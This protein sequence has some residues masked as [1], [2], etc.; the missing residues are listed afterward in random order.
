MGKK[1]V[2]GCRGKRRGETK[3]CCRSHLKQTSSALSP[4]ISFANNILVKNFY[5]TWKMPAGAT[6]HTANVYEI[7]SVDGHSC[8]SRHGENE[9]DEAVLKFLQTRK[10]D[11]CKALPTGYLIGHLYAR[12]VITLQ[13]RT[14]FLRRRD[15]VRAT[16]EQLSEHLLALM[17]S[18]A[19]SAEQRKGFLRVID[20]QRAPGL[21]RNV[22]REIASFLEAKTPEEHTRYWNEY[23]DVE[24]DSLSSARSNDYQALCVDQ[25]DGALTDDGGFFFLLSSDFVIGC[26]GNKMNTVRP[27]L[28]Q[29]P[30]LIWVFDHFWLFCTMA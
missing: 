10:D 16:D 22:L 4:I 17:E 5:R 20:E 1:R 9:V 26:A 19:K 12:E 8:T 15:D 24:L 29:D 7:D 27:R 25:E 21:T 14:A 30:P 3:T 6:K 11:L 23:E 2:G 13:E 18:S 28:R